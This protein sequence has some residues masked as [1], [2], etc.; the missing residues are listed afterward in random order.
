MKV[1]QYDVRTG[2]DLWV[3]T[4]PAGSYVTKT[5]DPFLVPVLTPSDANLRVFDLRTK[6]E[7]LNVALRPGDLTGA[8]GVTVLAD[9]TY[10]VVAING[11]TRSAGRYAACSPP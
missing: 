5:E 2:Q 7:V 10:F 3:E 4:F 11:P 8:H 1:R 9:G 6:K